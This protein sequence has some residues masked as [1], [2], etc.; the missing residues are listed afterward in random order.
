M[1][2]ELRGMPRDRSQIAGFVTNTEHAHCVR[3]QKIGFPKR[4]GE[5]TAIANLLV[6]AFRRGG[7]ARLGDDIAQNLQ[8]RGQRDAVF[9]EEAERSEKPGRAAVAEESGNS[10]HARQCR[11][12]RLSCLRPLEHEP[13]RQDE[14][15]ARSKH[16]VD[17]A[18]QPG[19]G[20]DHKGRAGIQLGSEILEHGFELRHHINQEKHQNE[21]GGADKETRIADSRTDPLGK[22][23]PPRAILD[24]GMHDRIEISRRLAGANHRDVGRLDDRGMPLKRVGEAFAG[25]DRSAQCAGKPRQAFAGIVAQCMQRRFQGHTRAQKQRQFTQERRHLAGICAD[26]KESA[27]A[28]EHAGGGGLGLDRHMPQI[29]DAPQH[30][31]A[32]RCFDL[33]CYEFPRRRDRTVTKLRHLPT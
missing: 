30:L 26:G 21:R 15:D 14:R 18:A 1:L 24:D 11:Y 20:R 5:T 22:Q 31:L 12:H 6:H 19:G 23:V 33:A 28:R 27:V 4:I 13:R 2:V 7:M 3:R 29:F 9:D 32:R 8:S 25:R 16:H 10:R 17:I